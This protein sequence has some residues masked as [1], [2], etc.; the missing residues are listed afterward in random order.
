MRSTLRF[1]SLILLLF[2]LFAISGEDFYPEDSNWAVPKRHVSLESDVSNAFCFNYIKRLRALWY[3]IHQ[4]G[5]E[6]VMEEHP[7]AAEGADP[8]K[9][10]TLARE[11]DAVS[12]DGAQVWIE[13]KWKACKAD[14]N[15]VGK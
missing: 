2:P 4:K 13:S 11:I 14:P 15:S 1:I 10:M 8:E 7:P 5:I 12:P 6:A 3:D 9:A